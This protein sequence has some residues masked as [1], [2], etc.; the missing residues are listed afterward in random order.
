M[1]RLIRRRPAWSS[2]PAPVARTLWLSAWSGNQSKFDSK[3]ADSTSTQLTKHITATNA[4]GWTC[5]HFACVYGRR[6]MVARI[7]DACPSELERP[8]TK[9]WT[10]LHFSAGF[11]HT[12]IIDDLLERGADREVLNTMA[13]SV[14]EGWTPL[15]RAIRWWLSPDKPNAVEHLIMAVGC[16]TE[17]RGAD[18]LRPIDLV[19]DDCADTLE[20]ILKRSGR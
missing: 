1:L 17:A 16:D 11:G 13:G 4:H 2:A 5:L 8:T 15:H 9:G 3:W 19:H 12:A 18:G 7:L 14:A 6:D 20:A 10:P